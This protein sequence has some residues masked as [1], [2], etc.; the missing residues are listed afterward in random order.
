MGFPHTVLD[1]RARCPVPGW[2]SAGESTRAGGSR[3]SKASRPRRGIEG[4]ESASKANR[5]AR[6][7]LARAGRLDREEA[8]VG[9]SRRPGRRP[10]R[11]ASA[12]PRRLTYELS[13]PQSI[14]DQGPVPCVPLSP[15]VSLDTVARRHVDGRAVG[16]R[17]SRDTSG[18]PRSAV[19]PLSGGLPVGECHVTLAAPFG[20]RPVRPVRRP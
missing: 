15:G 7:A 8:L 1:L 12:R 5:P 4:S 6:E 14:G 16:L 17:V 11:E 10:A 19:A 20:G 13:E 18:V 3:A 9:A 2:T